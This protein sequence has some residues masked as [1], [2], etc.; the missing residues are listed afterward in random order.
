ML[1]TR[2]HGVLIDVCE[3]HGLWL[4]KGELADVV[5]EI[6]NAD[7]RLHVQRMEQE[8]DKLKRVMQLLTQVLDASHP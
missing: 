2:Q 5:G 4:D 8:A 1:S 3:T 7:I 6:R